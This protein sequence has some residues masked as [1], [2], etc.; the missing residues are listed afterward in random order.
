MLSPGELPTRKMAFTSLSTNH[1]DLSSGCPAQFRKPAVFLL[2]M[3]E[4]AL[5]HLNLSTSCTRNLLASIFEPVDW[6]WGAA[7]HLVFPGPVPVV[8]PA[9]LT[10]IGGDPV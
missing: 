8:Q 5:D 2:V 6:R 4:Q 1:L 7:F 9:V 3:R 10:V